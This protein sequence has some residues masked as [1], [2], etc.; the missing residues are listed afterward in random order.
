M[1]G[2]MVKGSSDMNLFIPNAFWSSWAFG[3]NNISCSI[4]IKV[5]FPPLSLLYE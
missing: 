2:N 1:D 3:E 5:L 4:D